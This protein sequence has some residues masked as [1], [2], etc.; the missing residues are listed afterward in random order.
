MQQ[1]GLWVLALIAASPLPHTPALL[2]VALNEPNFIDIL[3]AMWLGKALKYGG[4]AWLVAKFPDTQRV[5]GWM[6]RLRV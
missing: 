4:V 2:M 6:A 3:L 1:H 5:R